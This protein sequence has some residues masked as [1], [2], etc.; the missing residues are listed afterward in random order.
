MA[1]ARGMFQLSGAWYQPCHPRL[2]HEGGQ[3]L[4]FDRRH[5]LSEAG[6]TVVT[7]A[8]IGVRRV[9]TFGQLL[10]QALLEHSA[11]GTVE[12][13]GAQLDFARS[14]GRDILHDGVA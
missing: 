10:D 8:L 1:L 9:G 6:E 4:H 3:A 14:P 7:P 13:S 5:A 12:R 2:P 11:D